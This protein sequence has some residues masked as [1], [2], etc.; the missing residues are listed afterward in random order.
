MPERKHDSNGL[1]DRHYGIDD[2]IHVACLVSS[3]AVSLHLTELQHNCVTTDRVVCCVTTD[4]VAAHAP[5]GGWKV[6]GEILCP[7]NEQQRHTLSLEW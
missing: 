5:G 3:S 4:R 2:E 6:S 7:S 1:C